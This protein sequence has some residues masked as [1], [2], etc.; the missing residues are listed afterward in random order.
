ATTTAEPETTTSTTTTTSK[1][2]T[3][4]E[5]ETTTSTTTTTSKATTTAEPETTTSTTTTTPTEKA[6]ANEEPETTTST[7]TTT[8]TTTTKPETT[9]STT[10]TITPIASA[11]E[12]C[13]WSVKDYNKKHKDYN[14]YAVSAEIVE[15]SNNNYKITL[16]DNSD[17]VLDVYEIDS[18]TGIGEDSHGEEVNLPQTG[19]NSV[20][21]IMTVLGALMTTIFG[22][23]AV[24]FSGI[25][26]RKENK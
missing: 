26:R 2:T 25:I 19:N 22:F 9:T 14:H 12:L 10:T 17:N 5:P 6:R 18:E 3:T 8:T 4:A 15:E 13:D 21:D 7:T 1:A 23:V 11:E 16:K 24:K 20:T